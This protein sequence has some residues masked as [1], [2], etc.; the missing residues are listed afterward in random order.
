M[1]NR[2]PPEMLRRLRNEIPIALVIAEFLKLPT[3]VSE[4]YLRFL[5]PLCTEFITATNPKT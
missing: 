4:G 2:L 3:K 1:S 5:C